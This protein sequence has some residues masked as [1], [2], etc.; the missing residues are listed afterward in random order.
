MTSS[1]DVQRVGAERLRIRGCQ[2]GEPAT[3][4]ILAWLA[5][6]G[7]VVEH[8]HRGDLGIIEV[9]YRDPPG[10][11]GSFLRVLKDRAFTLAQPE[12]ERRSVTIAHEI[13][14]RVR[15]RF[16]GLGDDDLVR[17]A[18]WLEGLPGVLR[19]SASPASLSILVL[20][21]PA[22]TGAPALLAAARESAPDAWPAAAAKPLRPEW[23]SM[24]FN[25]VVLAATVA[26]VAPPVALGAAIALTA[27]PSARRAYRALT[28]RR[29]SVDLLDLAAIGIS[30]GTGQPLTAS[31]I[32]W[33]LGAG[34]IILA[35]TTDRARQ[36][37]SKLM[38]LDAE[39][40]WRIGDDGQTERVSVK[41]LGIGDRIVVEAGGRIAADGLVDR[42]LALV[43]EKA[44]TGESVPCERRSG[45]R[46]LAASVVVEGQLVI[47]V[48][49]VGTDTTAAKIVQ[50]LEGAGAKPMTL[51]RH[52]ERFADHL[53]LPTFGVAG[54]A[55]ALSAQI[56]RMTS[57]LI[58]DFGTG[59][60]IA[61]PTAALAAM[62]AAAR[63]GVLV[64]GGK[65]LERLAKVD[66]IVFDKTGTLTGGAP[67]IFEVVTTGRL[68]LREAI[69]LAAA[70]EARQGHPVAEAVRQHAAA[71]GLDVPEAEL[72][73]ETYTIGAG[74]SARV[75]G[76]AVLVG[77]LRLM[78]REGVPLRGAAEEAAARHRR[79]GASSLCVAIDGRI[80]AVIG[81]ADEPRPESREVV[82]ALKA[83]G[84]R[85]VILMSGDAAG[86]VA[87]IA[88]RVGVDRALP[89]LLPEDKA[90][91]VR[92]LQRAGKTVAMVGDGINDAPALAV[93]DVGISL[94]GG[95]EVALETADVVLL[96]GGLLKLPDA[97][98]TADRAMRHVH[99][100]LGLVI[101]P[102][103]IAICAGAAGL[104][105][106]GVA[107]AVNNG[108]TIVAALAGLEPLLRTRAKKK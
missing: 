102:N 77:S 49:R 99:R 85:Q 30:I 39:D 20:F 69:A 74:L 105:T 21:E 54:A 71:M 18:S 40:A 37:I 38:Q 55:F 12:A 25:T 23:R 73:S 59:I 50:I 81:Y 24:A 9:H 62:T 52:T 97:F 108:S 65:F 46:V 32:T 60:R 58:T 56:D 104:I 68:P 14:G 83:G 64:K 22:E 33:L 91:H 16:A 48:D 78:N 94:H 96:E 35:Q 87:A 41:R 82:R 106:P 6:R 26:E 76:H 3:A 92:A 70:A 103:A 107:A 1:L 72:G 101:V 17:L 89:E 13:E 66:A 5:A 34:D 15:L 31:F 90:H 95:T 53:V 42:G 63:E 75:A 7:E 27:I 11:K 93:A 84:R 19:A 44:L 79:A 10:G 28:E 100:G 57:V 8:T 45:E 2:D 61:V 98:D 29:A 67:E 51:Q 88:A 86:P 80:E 36:A 43:D 4:A 47:T